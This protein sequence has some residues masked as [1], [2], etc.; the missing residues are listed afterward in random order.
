MNHIITTHKAELC[1][2]YNVVFSLHGEL[3]PLAELVMK[4]FP[5]QRIV[6]TSWVTLIL[7]DTS[8]R[9]SF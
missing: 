3:I 1:L 7:Q 5:T 2:T 4:L 6:C 9:L 8:D